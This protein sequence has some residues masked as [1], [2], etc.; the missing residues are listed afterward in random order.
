[1]LFITFRLTEAYVTH[2]GSLVGFI[3]RD[4]LKRAIDTFS[5]SPKNALKKFCKFYAR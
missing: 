1:M 5:N 4:I 2:N 3:N